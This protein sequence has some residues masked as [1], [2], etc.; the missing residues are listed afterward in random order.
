MRLLVKSDQGFKKAPRSR[1]IGANIPTSGTEKPINILEPLP[2][3]VGFNYGKGRATRRIKT[4]LG[5][6]EIFC[7]FRNKEVPNWKMLS[8]HL[9]R[10]ISE[11]DS[12]F[13]EARKR[14]SLPY[15]FASRV[16]RGCAPPFWPQL[17]IKFISVAGWIICQGKCLIALVT[18]YF[19]RIKHCN[20][21]ISKGG[22]SQCQK[23]NR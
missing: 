21:L 15:M 3:M 1:D 2:R 22:F 11:Y 12:G 23:E 13:R 5:Y 16:H 7:L 4:N 6:L 14:L 10:C 8:R 19:K 17:I 9:V 18:A 20:Y